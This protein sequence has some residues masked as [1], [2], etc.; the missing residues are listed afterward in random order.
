MHTR[1]RPPSH[2]LI[3]LCALCLPLAAHAGR[4]LSTDDASTAGDQNYQFEA[5]SQHA[6]G[7]HSLSL[8]PAV[9]FGSF[10]F[11]F[12]TDR[13]HEKEGLKTR[14]NSAYIKWAPESLNFEPLRFGAK[15]WM[16]QSKTRPDEENQTERTHGGIAIATW[17]ITDSLAAHFDAGATHSSI[18][19]RTDRIGN[20]ALAWSANERVLLFVEA[21]YQ[22]RSGTTQAT[23]LRYW[24]IP[25][26]FGVDFTVSRQA[27]VS[28]STSIGVGFGWYSDFGL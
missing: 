10:E 13:I 28:N 23:G 5:W 22:Q 9:G 18:E 12:E 24:A 16:G 6:D 4:P 11:G 8:A 14:A 19:R 25:Q 17:T 27:G 20:A 7:T 15:I 21:L 2:W 26:K 3:A 1:F